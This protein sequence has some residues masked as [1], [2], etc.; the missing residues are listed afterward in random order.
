MLKRGDNVQP[1]GWEGRPAAQFWVLAVFLLV[2]LLTGGSSQP[3]VASLQILRP[4]A[5]LVTAYA[6]LTMRTEHWRQHRAIFVVLGAVILLTVLHLVPLPPD[7][8]HALP[9]RALIRDVDVL[10]GVSNNWRPLSMVPA[11]TWNALYALA[12]PVAVVLL[13]SQLDRAENT[14]ILIVLIVLVALSGGIGLIQSIGVDL[15][16]Y[17]SA[18][19][20][21]GLLANR[22]HQAVLLVLLFPMLATVTRIKRAKAGGRAVTILSLS[23]AAITIPLILV[24]GSRSGFLI[25][26]LAAAIVVYV[27]FEPGV[28]QSWGRRGLSLR[29]GGVLAVAAVLVGLMAFVGRDSAIGRLQ[30]VVDDPRLPI[31]NSIV[32]ALPTYMPW[33][34]GIGSYALAYQVHEPD[35]LLR[36]GFSNHAHNDYLEVLFT[37]GGPGVLILLAAAALF[38]ITLVR[39]AGRPGPDGLFSRLGVATIAILAIASVTDYPIRTPFLSA[40]FAA[41]VVWASSAR[42][43]GNEDGNSQRVA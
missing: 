35:R 20:G 30:G 34:T 26:I 18:D 8:W 36:P 24:T 25:A 15:R 23:L 43:F 12:V 17:Q 13:T 27:L 42:R 14:R 31:W 21:G 29:V 40:V 7:I 19:M 2:V 39:A 28:V 33:G 16:M 3:T 6:C 22:N 4:V 11:A 1:Q 38:G 41:A 10:V 37:A 32:A 5:I 9:G